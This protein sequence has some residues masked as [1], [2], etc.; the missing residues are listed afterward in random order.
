MVTEMAPY[1]GGC[2]GG[3]NSQE[4]VRS[5]NFPQSLGAGEEMPSRQEEAWGGGLSPQGRAGW[6]LSVPGGRLSQLT[7]LGPFCGVIISTFKNSGL[8]IPLVVQWLRR[9]APFSGGPGSSPG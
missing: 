6:S 9:Q 1:G 4:G 8:G 2:L 7:L 5:Q 3:E